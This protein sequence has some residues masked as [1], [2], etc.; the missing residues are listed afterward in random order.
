MWTVCTFVINVIMTLIIIQQ[1]LLNT[2]YMPGTVL[3]IVYRVLNKM[4]KVPAFLELIYSVPR[5]TDTKG[6][7]PQ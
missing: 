7:I 6:I 5:E 2:Y 1:M 4:D 3:E